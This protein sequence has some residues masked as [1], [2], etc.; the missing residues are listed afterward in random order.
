MAI[1]SKLVTFRQKSR[2]QPVSN[3]AS[4]QKIVFDPSFCSLYSRLAFNIERPFLAR[5]QYKELLIWLSSR[6]S[7]ILIKFGCPVN[8]L[9]FLV[10]LSSFYQFFLYYIY[11][12][13]YTLYDSLALFNISFKQAC[14]AATTRIVFRVVRNW[15]HKENCNH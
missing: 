3:A 13:P 11:F 14:L 9:K 15:R 1:K 7:R 8:Y 10:W 12:Q 6:L 2:V 4:I 5:V